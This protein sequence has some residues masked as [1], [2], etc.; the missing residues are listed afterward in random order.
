MYEQLEASISDLESK[1]KKLLDEN[2]AYISEIEN[3]E[4]LENRCGQYQKLLEYYR[5]IS[6]C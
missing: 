1:N 3:I 6:E 4:K 5:T 2:R